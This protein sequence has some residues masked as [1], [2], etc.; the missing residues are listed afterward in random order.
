[1]IAKKIGEGKVVEGRQNFSLI[2]LT[3]FVVS[4]LV[5]AIGFI[6][7]YFIMNILGADERVHSMALE[8][9]Q[10]LLLFL[11]VIVLGM[12][13]QQFLITEGKAHISAITA[14]VGGITSASLNFVLIYLMDMGLSGAALATSI[15]YT[16]P[17]LVGLTYFAFNRKGNLYFVR[18]KFDI[19]ALSRTCIN[20]A[21]EMVTMLATSIVAVIMNNILMRIDG[22]EATAAAAIMFAGMGIFTSLFI[23]YSSGIIPIISYNFGKGDTDNLK[24]IYKNSLRMIGII[25]ASAVGLAFLSTNLLISIYDIPQ[26]TSIHDMATF[27]F[28]ALAVGFVLMGFNTFASMFFTALNNGLVSSFLSLFQTL[29]FPVA[30]F[31]VLPEIF[32]L[33]GAW[34]A[35]PTAEALSIVLTIVFFVKMKRRYG[36]A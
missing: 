8:Y 1:M 13:F 31:W 27:G 16:L 6:A 36:Y 25:S 29:I 32:G 34:V 9:M 5:A 17:A 2:V 10:P 35:I 28:R 11:P 3:A 24:R 4:I 15:G 30:A 23:G 19:R 14:L 20:G 33:T 21:S 7:P 18:P 12:V 22:M 26:G